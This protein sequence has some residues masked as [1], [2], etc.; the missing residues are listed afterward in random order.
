MP[1][2]SASVAA[3]RRST[4]DLDA[5]QNLVDAVADAVIERLTQQGKV[6]QR[7]ITFDLK[8]LMDYTGLSKTSITTLLREEKISARKEGVK[9]LYERAS[10][11]RYLRSLPAWGTQ[12]AA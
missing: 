8:G 9:N 2:S 5:F 11:D 12:E 7:P 3:V 10:V 6:D 1:N 4:V